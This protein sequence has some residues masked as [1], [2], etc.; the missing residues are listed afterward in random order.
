MLTVK[1]LNELDMLVGREVEMFQLVPKL[2]EIW[3]GV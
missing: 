1:T 3:A 2:K